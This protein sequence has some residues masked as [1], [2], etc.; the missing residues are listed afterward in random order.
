MP[1]EK[2]SPILAIRR[3]SSE[4]EDKQWKDKGWRKSKSQSKRMVY[5]VKRGKVGWRHPEKCHNPFW[6]EDALGLKRKLKDAA[7][8]AGKN[9]AYYTSCSWHQQ[10]SSWRCMNE[11]PPSQLLIKMETTFPFFKAGHYNKW[12]LSQLV[13]YSCYKLSWLKKTTYLIIVPSF[14]PLNSSMLFDLEDCS[15]ETCEQVGYV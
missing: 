7:N 11:H 10:L 12:W 6:Q 13:F 8:F 5:R 15:L 3:G 4:W 2:T 9:K 1:L 14:F